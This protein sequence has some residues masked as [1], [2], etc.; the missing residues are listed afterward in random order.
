LSKGNGNED[1]KKLHVAVV[2]VNEY[3]HGPMDI[4]EKN[5]EL[6]VATRWMQEKDEEMAARDI[7]IMSTE[8]QQQVCNNT[9]DRQKVTLD[10]EID[11]LWKLTM[12]NSR[13]GYHEMRS[14][15]I[16]KMQLAVRDCQQGNW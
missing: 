1:K 16:Q 2:D 15:V 11:A 7:H 3:F 5:K 12:K 6:I 14:V 4:K 13:W 10:I 8:V 9:M